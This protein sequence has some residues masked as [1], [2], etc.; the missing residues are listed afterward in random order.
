WDPLLWLQSRLS[1]DPSP[2]L[3]LSSH[4]ASLALLTEPLN[5]VRWSSLLLAPSPGLLFS[6]TPSISPKS[7]FPFYA[8]TPFA[9][10]PEALA[11]FGAIRCAQANDPVNAPF[12]LS[13]SYL[14]RC[15]PRP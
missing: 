3:R 2:Y 5:F 10:T 7:R 6:S 14:S 11:I 1:P 9:T 12:A 4:P 13:V 8:V 15:L